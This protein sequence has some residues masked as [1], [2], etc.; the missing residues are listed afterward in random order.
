MISFNCYASGIKDA[1]I[2]QINYRS[3]SIV[4]RFDKKFPTQCDDGGDW[5]VIHNDEST[6]G[7]KLISLIISAAA[8]GNLVN[9]WTGACRYHNTL[10]QFQVK[11]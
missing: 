2:V 11:Y 1:K 9:V 3:D 10:A 7:K 6:E 5:L 4:V 8:A